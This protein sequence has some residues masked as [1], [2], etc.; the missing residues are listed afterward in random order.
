MLAEIYLLQLESVR[1]QRLD[2]LRRQRA[3][4]HHQFD[5]RF[6]H[7]DIPFSPIVVR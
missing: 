5:R 7:I 6:V 2:M 1:R 4:I 3:P